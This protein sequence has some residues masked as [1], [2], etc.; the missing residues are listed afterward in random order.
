V[1]FK[2]IRSRLNRERARSVFA[3]LEHPPTAEYGHVRVRFGADVWAAAGFRPDQRVKPHWGFGE[4]AG[5][6]LILP[7]EA[8]TKLALLRRD[9]DRQVDPDDATLATSF[10]DLPDE[11]F[12]GVVGAEWT[13]LPDEPFEGVDG[14]EWTLLPDARASVKCVSRQ[15]GAGV[16]IELPREWWQVTSESQ[17]PTSDETSGRTAD[18]KPAMLK[19]AATGSA[20]E[21]AEVEESAAAVG[22]QTWHAPQTTPPARVAFSPPVAKVA[23]PL[24]V[25]QDKVELAIALIGEGL[26]ESQIITRLRCTPQ[27]LQDCYALRSERLSAAN[28]EAG[29]TNGAAAQ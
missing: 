25:K 2:Q 9:S 15:H 29:R 5:S 24:P 22:A 11:P 16:L 18:Q 3:S 7:N 23:P 6:I 14:A 20:R 27:F 26:L 13:L 19:E 21:R 17:G 1:P 4:D 10:A 28:A 8:G 12:E